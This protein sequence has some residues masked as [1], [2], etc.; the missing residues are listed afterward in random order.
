[1]Q[2]FEIGITEIAH[3]YIVVKAATKE[4][5]VEKLR[6][7]YETNEGFERINE[8]LQES[9]LDWEVTTVGRTDEEAEV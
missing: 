7:W 3:A 2:N 1:M 8:L 9:I 6:K 4:E 5:A